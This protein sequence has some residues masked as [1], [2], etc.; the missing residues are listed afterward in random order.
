LKAVLLHNGNYNPSVPIA[1]VTEMTETY[2]TMKM[3]LER[4]KYGESKWSICGDLKVLGLLLGLQSGY[5]KYSCFLCMWNSR[6]SNNHYSKKKWPP[7]ENFTPGSHNVQHLPIVDL[8]KVL[9]PPLHIKLGLMKNFVKA[10]AV[11]GAGLQYLRD[12]FP[13]IS[14]AKLRAGIFIGPKIRAILSDS[15][16]EM[17]L[18]QNERRA[19]VSFRLVVDNFLESNKAT[20]YKNMVN[21]L[22]K[23]YKRMGC[24]MSI[25]CIFCTLIWTS[26]QA[27]WETLATSTVKDSTRTSR[28][29][30]RGTK[31]E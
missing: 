20:S 22:L 3:L 19:W 23:N 6:D 16:F 21:N 25:K 11:E 10:L 15:D 27:T 13:S 1:H 2:D 24:R 30:S 26:F 12:K 7:R 14:E 8:T 18:T 31:G 5:T 29:W 28:L 4:I 17:S 9:L